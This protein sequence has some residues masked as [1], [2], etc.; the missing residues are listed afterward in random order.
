MGSMRDFVSWAKEHATPIDRDADPSRFD[1][2]SPLKEIVGGARI[3]SFG[4]SQHYT[5]EFNRLRSRLFRFLVTQMGFTTFVLEVGLVEAK[6]THDYVLGL[7]DDAEGAYLATNQTFGLWAEQQEMLQW[8]REYN[9]RAPDS[10]KIRFY[11][12]DGSEGW[13]H[14]ATAVRA[15]CAYLDRVDPDYAASLRQS[16]EPLAESITLYTL[17]DTPTKRFRE[18]VHRLTDLVGNFE[19]WKLQYIESSSNEDFDWAYRFALVAR[20]ICT[21]LCT[22]RANPDDS[23]RAWNNIRDF[24]MAS[25][26]KWILDREG[27]DARLFL[28][29]HN[30]HFQQVYDRETKSDLSTMGQYLMSLLPNVETVVVAGTNYFSLKPEDHALQDS[31]QAALDEL[32]IPSFLLDLR[33]ATVDCEALEWLSQERSERANINYHRLSM[34]DAYDAV[35]FVRNIELD[36]LRLPESLQQSA[37]TLDATR[38]EGLVGTYQFVGVLREVD[39]LQ[40]SIDGERLY[41][42]VG[43]SNGELFPMYKSELVASSDTEFFWREWPMRLEF[44]R[45]VDGVARKAIIHVPNMHWIFFGNRCN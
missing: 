40:V 37:I 22:F 32:G 29:A 15:A 16:L 8:M 41:S 26:L 23:L 9:C 20:Q 2:L 39:V 24:S 11:G 25:N 6:K 3:V 34:R 5:H 4:E 36:E 28:G 14:T 45:D 27:P 18:L 21:M 31:N 10:E 44:E 19:I 43:E 13:T 17:A 12:M 35:L 33:S 30:A 7:H 38:L 42:N 1:D